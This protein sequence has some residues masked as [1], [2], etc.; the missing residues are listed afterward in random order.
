MNELL[1]EIVP[2][3]PAAAPLLVVLLFSALLY[4]LGLLFPCGTCC[5]CGN[6]PPD[7]KL[8][9]TLTVILSGMPDAARGPWLINLGFS[10]SFGFGA[11]GR[12]TAPGG[13][14]GG[15]ISAAEVLNGGAGYAVFG[16]EEPSLLITGSGNGATFTP[17]LMPSTD[18]LGR[19]V[20]VVDAVALGGNGTFYSDGEF[21]T[22]TVTDG[23]GTPPTLQLRTGRSAPTLTASVVGSTGSGAALEVSLEETTDAEGRPAWAVEFITV[24]DGGLNYQDGDFVEITILDGQAAAGGWFSATVTVDE[25]G[26]VTGVTVTSGGR[27]FDDDGVPS[28]VLILSPGAMWKDNPSLPPIVADVEV[29]I[30]QSPPSNGTGAVL[31]AVIDQVT[32]SPTF[33]KIVGVTIANA[34]TGYRAWDFTFSVCCSQHYNRSYVLKQSAADKCVYQHDF[35][36][37]GSLRWAPG[38]LR[39]VYGG[40]N[41]IRI[42]LDHENNVAGVPQFEWCD[43]EWHFTEGRDCDDLNF[44]VELPDGRK[45]TVLANEPEYNPGLLY[46]GSRSCHMCC[47]GAGPVNPEI[48]AVVTGS[49]F[50]AFP[51]GAYVLAQVQPPAAITATAIWWEMSGVLDP[52]APDVEASLIVRLDACPQDGTHGFG[53]NLSCFDRCSTTAELQIEFGMFGQGSGEGPCSP[54]PICNPTGGIVLLSNAGQPVAT[55]TF[56]A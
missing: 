46:A 55:L 45:A 42:A 2:A 23:L 40:R 44:T 28:E 52:Q 41:N 51:N 34:G 38:F 32:T 8:P 19:P 17:T 37:A 53:N 26:G 39:L 6:C 48:T 12:V 18:D 36:G 47:R 3:G 29:L 43:T 24:T 27:F 35:C 1:A 56:A 4:P 31:E 21:L 25:D 30:S 50:P 11:S 5:N 22:A 16:R 7:Q 14:P 13:P 20:W 9:E 10:G 49:V 15:P 54:M 33:G